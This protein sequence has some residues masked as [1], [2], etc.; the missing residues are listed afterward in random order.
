M[1]SALLRL[2]PTRAILVGL[3][4]MLSVFTLLRGH[5][6]PG[7]GFAGG[8]LLAATLSIPLLSHGAAEARRTL[9]VDPRTLVGV[10]LLLVVTAAITGLILGGSLLTPWWGPEVAG[11][12]AL[13]TVFLF[14]LGVYLSVA[15]TVLSILLALVEEH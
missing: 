15:G 9:R 11:V 10:G 13:G 5:R 3:F 7:G 4:A 12:G 8:L 2:G 6:E 1:A 14:D